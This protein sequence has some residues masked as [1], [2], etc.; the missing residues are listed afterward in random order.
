MAHESE[1][2]V[3]ELGDAIEK[4]CGQSFHLVNI[5]SNDGW[6]AARL[7]LRF[8][9][10][11][12]TLIDAMPIA[13]P[14]AVYRAV[15]GATTG[16]SVF[17]EMPDTCLSSNYHRGQSTKVECQEYRLPD[18]LGANGLP[19][20]TALFIDTEGTTGDILKGACDL[21]AGVRFICAEVQVEMIYPGCMLLGEVDELLAGYGLVRVPGGYPWGCQGNYF[22]ARLAS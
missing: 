14:P 11:R 12:L 18:W 1:E 4:Y 20:P 15:I 9:S 17:Y 10:A 8:P 19:A 5:G 21:L 2:F 13:G 3:S 7:A 6:E 22:W 16:Q